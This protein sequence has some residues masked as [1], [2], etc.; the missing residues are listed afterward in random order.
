MHTEEIFGKLWDMY[1]LQNPS[2][3]KIHKLFSD[4]GEPVVNDHIAFRTFNDPR[5]NIDI[6]AK[7]FLEMGYKEAGQYY[8]K[9]KNLNAKHF[10]LAGEENAPRVFISELI[11]ENVSN[12]LRKVL[13][14]QIEHVEQNIF[15]TIDLIFAGSIFNPLSYKLY[16]E[17]RKE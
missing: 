5:M 11:L 2:A 16:E 12:P 6:L 3:L 13:L 17:I 14:D 4:L 9:D 8:F 7:P 10:E 1:T 15:G